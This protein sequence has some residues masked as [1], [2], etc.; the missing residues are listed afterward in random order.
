MT[1]FNRCATAPVHFQHPVSAC[2]KDVRTSQ[3]QG[4]REFLSDRRL[5]FRISREVDAARGLIEHNNARAPEEGARH[6]DQLPLAL[7]EV[8]SARRNLS[9]EG[10]RCLAV[11]SHRHRAWGG[12][13]GLVRGGLS[14]CD[15]LT[16]R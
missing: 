15:S 1:V 2:S 16:N 7:G 8:R 14:I 5:D 13:T 11:V 10:D 4:V 9:I 3:Q 6:R 12:G